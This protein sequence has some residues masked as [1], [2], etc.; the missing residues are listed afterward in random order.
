MQELS[1]ADIKKIR[2]L[3]LAEKASILLV[4]RARLEPLIT[5]DNLSVEDRAPLIHD[6]HVLLHSRKQENRK[7]KQIEAALDRLALGDFGICQA[8]GQPVP[9]KRLLAIPW[10]DRCVVCEEQWQ[11][12][13][14]DKSELEPAA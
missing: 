13:K 8:C 3:L 9:R 1:S 10:A 4:P 12:G 7:L 5:P 6:Q 11:D 14:L 2:E